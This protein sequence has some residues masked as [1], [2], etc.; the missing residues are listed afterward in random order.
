MFNISFIKEIINNYFYKDYISNYIYYDDSF[1]LVLSNILD[2]IKDSTY[3]N[4][5]C[6]S[7]LNNSHYIDFE[8]LFDK[9]SILLEYQ[10]IILLL[11]QILAQVNLID[12]TIVNIN[13]DLLLQELATNNHFHFIDF[14]IIDYDDI[15][16]ISLESLNLL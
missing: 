10:P 7:F 9:Y 14:N 4:L 1:Y 2:K 16:N 15:N 11:Y 8:K 13:G 3:Y 6:Q 12:Y 5:H